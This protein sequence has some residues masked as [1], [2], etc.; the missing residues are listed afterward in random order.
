M[1]L[2]CLSCKNE[3][4]ESNYFFVSNQSDID[5]NWNDKLPSSKPSTGVSGECGHE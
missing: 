4:K 2:K 3:K 5:N 1:E